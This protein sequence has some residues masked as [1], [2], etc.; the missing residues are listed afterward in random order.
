[1]VSVLYQT[2]TRCI[3]VGSRLLA[4]LLCVVLLI[5]GLPSR[6]EAAVDTPPEPTSLICTDALLDSSISRPSAT[7]PWQTILPQVVFTSASAQVFSPPQAILLREDDDGVSDGSVDVDAF[8]QAFTAPANTE[9]VIG[10]LQ[11]RIAPGALGPGD[12]VT[13]SLNL[14][15]NPTPSGRIFAVDLPLSGRADGNWRSFTWAATDV[16]PL[17][18]AG[19]ALFM[20]TLRGVNDSA[21]LSISF[22][23]IEAQVCRRATATLGGRVTQQNR[24]APDLSNAQVLLLRYDS[25]GKQ[26]VATAQVAL[27]DDGFRYRFDVPPLSADALYQVWFA[28]QPL[29]AGRDDQRLGVLAG[30]VI[31]SLAAGQEVTDLDLEVSTVK[32]LDPPPGVQ[33]V[34]NDENPVRFWIE[35]RG[36][37]DEEYQICLY[38]PGLI[39]SV[40]G[41]PPQ[42]CSPPLL[43]TAPFF[44]LTPAN[45]T[46]MPLRYNYPYR[47]YAV[48]RDNRGTAAY[49]A[50][51]YSFAEHTITFTVAPS[52]PPAQF[53]SDEGLLP[54]A[55][56]ANWTVL[57][58]VA[59]DNALGDQMRL[60]A[61]AQPVVELER[62]RAL[63][64]SYPNISL[65]TWFDGYGDTGGQIC[66][67]RGSAVDCRR[68]LEPNS[69]DPATLRAFVE[70]GLT[71]FPAN[72]VMLVLVGPAHPAL[73]F[74]SDET[75]ASAPAMSIAALGTALTEATT[76]V[77]KRI[78]LV[79]MQAPLTA[80]LTM[81]AALAPA[82]SYLVAP[83]GQLWRVAWLNRVL[84]RL[85]TTGSNDPRAVA[86]DLPA[87]YGSAVRADGVLREYAM[88]AF[89][90]ARV[91]AV[92][93]ARDTLAA[94]LSEVWN[95][96]RAT[97]ELLFVEV[98]ANSVIYDT[99][100]NGLGDEMRDLA[101]DRYDAPEDAFIDLG[102]FTA[103][104]AAAPALQAS[105]LAAARA[106]TE[107]LAAAMGGSSPFVIAA[108][109]QAEGGIGIPSLPP[110][111][112]LAEFFPHRS[113]LGAQ[114]LLVERL[115][116]RGQTDSWSAFLRRYL[117]ADR[118]F[119]IGGVTA[120][121][122]GGTGL[123]LI[124][125]RPIAYERYL[126]I[127]SRQV[128]D[129]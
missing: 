46:A 96:R 60:S 66:A 70:Y 40:T 35:P 95:E 123:P 54:G 57:I 26:V 93:S 88:A 29:T 23:E 89:D 74:G 119:G 71:A 99:S 62:L 72:R 120:A 3:A 1:M 10:S 58:Y 65:V 39:D 90:L 30:P 5:A 11:Y 102:D 92:R 16:G 37:D 126:P 116:Y 41:M 73:G 50:F 47:W 53:S 15:D 115:L 22:D 118:L 82:A 111:A 79:L 124:V 49:P 14:P 129:E 33:R 98:R 42:V 34:L 91:N 80:N 27:T 87:L 44:D 122:S 117:A 127:V 97:M 106:A 63:A 84:N 21:A 67:L 13:V 85:T 104:L 128:N 18:E 103:L 20:I 17:V 12:T 100:G 125:G 25:S 55:A 19:S 110:G 107:A 61:V 68:Q 113:L 78:D 83:P 4:L 81:A 9:Q 109:R 94:E 38:D 51:G 105:E 114:P 31:T 121:P 59:A 24:A 69:A 52:S 77:G 76:A 43:S 56:S 108:R 6:L 2:S 36:I 48:A 32:L 101:G 8:G 7:S 64:P 75:T 112:G 86:I 45:F 28:N